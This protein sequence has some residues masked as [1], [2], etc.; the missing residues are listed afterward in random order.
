MCP[1]S[2]QPGDGRLSTEAVVNSKKEGQ[3]NMHA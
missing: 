2:L 1:D 3:I